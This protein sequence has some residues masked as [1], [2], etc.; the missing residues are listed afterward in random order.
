[1]IWKIAQLHN[2]KSR[3]LNGHTTVVLRRKKG[4]L[5]DRKFKLLG[6]SKND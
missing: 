5:V 1:M 3:E 4:E 2:Q 6:A